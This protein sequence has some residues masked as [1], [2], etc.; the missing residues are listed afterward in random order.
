MLCQE[1]KKCYENYE[2]CKKKKKTTT[3]S[4]EEKA[5]KVNRLR[6]DLD[7]RTIKRILS[8]IINKLKNLVKKVDNI[9][10]WMNNFTKQ[11]IFL[12]VS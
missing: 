1:F 11:K 3:Y 2:T 6:N 5:I 4:E 12:K 7:A 8:I 10:K 9:Y